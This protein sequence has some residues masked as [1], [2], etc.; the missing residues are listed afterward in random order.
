M[1]SLLKLASIERYRY[2]QAI[3]PCAFR[4]FSRRRHSTTRTRR[5]SR[6]IRRVFHFASSSK[7]L[8][9]GSKNFYRISRASWEDQYYPLISHPFFAQIHFGTVSI[10]CLTGPTYFGA[11]DPTEI[12][13]RNEGCHFDCFFAG[14]LAR[15][16]A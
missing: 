9:R 12:L 13:A 14:S 3:P 7:G 4:D 6:R 10:L 15:S 2:P 8:R 1:T 11:I 5:P 16:R